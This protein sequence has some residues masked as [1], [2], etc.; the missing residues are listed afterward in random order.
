MTY[1]T[2]PIIKVLCDGDLALDTLRGIFTLEEVVQVYVDHRR[3]EKE[4][5]AMQAAK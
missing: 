2:A 5:T 4:K 3:R 1:D